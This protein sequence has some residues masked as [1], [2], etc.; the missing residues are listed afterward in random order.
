MSV[1]PMMVQRNKQEVMMMQQPAQ[2]APSKTIPQD[3][4]DRLE[5]EWK[6][7]QESPARQPAQR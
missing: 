3:V 5:S 4:L 7:M 2:S 6:Q 1:A